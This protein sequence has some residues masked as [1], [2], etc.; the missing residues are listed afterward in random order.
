[1]ATRT[2]KPARKARSPAKGEQTLIPELAPQ[3]VDKIHRAAK[4]YAEARDSRVALNKDE[5]EAHEHLL[6]VMRELGLK[7]YEYGD[8]KVFVDEQTKCKVKIGG[9][10]AA[11]DEDK[12]N[13]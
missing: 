3:R 11:D 9:T 4:R 1:M 8:L 7:S 6:G 2:K 5:K 12:D 13:E 10:E